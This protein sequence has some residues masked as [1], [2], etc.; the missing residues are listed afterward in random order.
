MGMGSGM[1]RVLLGKSEETKQLG[2]PRCRWKDSMKI[3]VQEVGCVGMDWIGLA[4][5]RDK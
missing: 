2:R 4:Q 5:D 3:D 1:Y